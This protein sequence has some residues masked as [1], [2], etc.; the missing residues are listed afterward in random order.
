MNYL[1]E[2]DETDLSTNNKARMIT[3][4]I[5]PTYYQ[6]T[7]GNYID[8]KSANQQLI[9]NQRAAYT[10]TC[11]RLSE[12]KDISEENRKKYLQ[13][14]KDNMLKTEELYYKDSQAIERQ[15]EKERNLATAEM[16]FKGIL[17]I[18]GLFLA[19]KEAR[20]DYDDYFFI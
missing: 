14:A 9:Y 6:P 5:T 7:V 16:T 8:N 18:A 12:R 15:M 17:S 20:D 10:A 11:L 2:N 19:V 13:E 1:Y 4:I 3:P